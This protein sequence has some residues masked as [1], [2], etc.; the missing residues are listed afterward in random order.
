MRPTEGWKQDW[1]C[2]ENAKFENE[3]GAQF[4]FIFQNFW[5][6]ENLDAKSKT[7]QRRYSNALHALGGY[8]IAEAIRLGDYDRHP[9]QMVLDSLSPFE[10]PL[11]SPDNE[12]CQRGIDTVCRKLYKYM[13]QSLIILP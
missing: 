1:G 3:T 5:K 13:Q 10:G 9:I 6:Y 7:T 12:T 11:V 2:G 4:V 8:L